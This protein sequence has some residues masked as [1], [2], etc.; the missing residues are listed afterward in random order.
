[1][2]NIIMINKSLLLVMITSISFQAI[3]W[4]AET[5]KRC[6]AELIANLQMD[7]AAR[8]QMR[9]SYRINIGLTLDQI[10][11]AKNGDTKQA[12]QPK[13]IVFLVFAVLAFLFLLTLFIIFLANLCC[14]QKVESSPGKT[15]AYI[16]LNLIFFVVFVVFIVLSLAYSIKMNQDMKGLNCEMVKL[17]N[18]VINGVNNADNYFIGITPLIDLLTQLQTDIQGISQVQS[19]FQNIVNMNLPKAT[20]D[21]ISQANTF[22]S[23]YINTKIQ[24]GDGTQV[25]PLTG[26]DHLK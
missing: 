19:N 4:K 10:K 17:P 18:Y 22:E 6:T 12:A 8:V 3:D 21:A 23:T 7:G 11:K 24:A 2:K 9:D 20:S 13:P 26:G 15:N 25:V 5:S 1:M 14:C 16:L